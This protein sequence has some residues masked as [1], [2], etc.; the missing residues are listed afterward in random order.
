MHRG[1][2]CLS[3]VLISCGPPLPDI[4]AGHGWYCYPP[5]AG[6]LFADSCEREPDP[7][8]SATPVP[9]SIAWCY[10]QEASHTAVGTP[11]YAFTD[12]WDTDGACEGSR[13]M[14]SN[15]GWPV[16]ECESSP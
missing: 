5:N 15:R 11:T 2:I 14:E 4:P 3:L 1:L 16:S 9:T 7:T 12:C 8:A 6:F 13:L 10:T